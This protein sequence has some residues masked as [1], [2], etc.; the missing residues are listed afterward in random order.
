MEDSF[1]PLHIAEQ[2]ARVMFTNAVYFH[3]SRISKGQ[4]PSMLDYS[5]INIAYYAYAAVAPDGIIHVSRV[6]RHEGNSVTLMFAASLKM[7]GPI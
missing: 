4:T 5:C 6:W 2:M 7:Y 3:N 1:P